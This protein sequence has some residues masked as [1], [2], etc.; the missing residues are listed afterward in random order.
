MK[1]IRKRMEG[2]GGGSE[3]LGDISWGSVWKYVGRLLE[4]LKEKEKP[5]GEILVFSR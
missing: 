1:R 3:R 4:T 5:G 2:I